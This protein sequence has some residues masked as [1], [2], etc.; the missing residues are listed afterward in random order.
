MQ[1]DYPVF[2][3]TYSDEELAEHFLLT[4]AEGALVETCRGDVNRHGIA[5]LLKTVQYLGYF[6]DTL[7]RVPEVV[8]TFIAHQLHLL[9]DHTPAY[10]RHPST[11][12]VHV[13]VIRQHLGCRFPTGEDK[14]ALELWLRTQGALDAPTEDAL[15]EC[16]YIRLRA[17]G[18]ELPAPQE[19][20][21]L[22]QAALRGFFQDVYDQV[23]ARLSMPVRT[24]L[25][26]LLVVPPEET[27]SLFD[28]LKADPAAPGVQALQQ[29]VAML[30]ALRA[31]ALPGDVLADVPLKV[32]QLLKRRAHNED[33]SRMRAHPAPIRYTLLASFIHVRM[34]EVTDDT[35]RMTLD[36]IRRIETQTEKHLEKALL[37]DIKRVTGKVQLLYRIAEAVVEAPDGTIRNVLFPCV[38]EATFHDLVAEAKA[39]HPHYRIWYQ[40]IMRQKFVRHYRR[41]LPLILDHLTFC[42]ENRFQPVIKALA[43]IKQS[44]GTEGPYLPA[45]VPVEGVVSPRWRETVIEE[46]EGTTRINRPYYELCVLQRLERALKCKEIWVEGAYAFRNPSQD[47][48]VNWHHEDQRKVYYGTLQHPLD[49]T[50]FLDPLRHRLTQALTQFNR[51]LP[52]NPYVHLSTPAANEDRRLFTV[53]PLVAQPEP[54]S[55]GHLKDLIGQRYG[56]LDLVDIVL[57]ADRLVDFTRFFT[58]SGTKEVRS[59]DTLRPLLL[60]DLFA[61]GT[62]TGIKRVAN[63]NQH[64][65]FHE[66]LYVRKHYFSVEALRLAN[67][68]VV[69]KILAVRNPQLWGD[70]HACASD[71]KRFESWRQNLMTEWRSRY[72]GYGIL[73]YWHVETNAVC[74]YSQLRNFSFS[75][76]A[77]MIEGLIRHDTEMRVE[78]NFVDSHG[79]S[80][81]AFAFCHLLGGVRLMPRLKR[82]KYERLYV[83]DKGM[84]GTFPN[85][86]G[87]LSRPIRWDFIAQQYD[88][89]MKHAVA[90]KLGTATPEAILK[91]FNSYNVTH[92]TYKALAELGKVEKTIYLCEY[93]SSL[94]LRHEVEAGLNGVERWNEAND[95]IRYGRQGIFAT[96][97][98]E[99]Q[100]IAALCLQLIQNCL[101]LINAILVE[102]TVAQHQ[103][104]EHFS[105]ED[106]RA[107]TPLFY[108]HVNPYGLVAL[109]VTRPSFL[110][111]A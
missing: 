9:W 71:G 82:I 23:A 41:M 91:R 79:Q 60:L 97:S 49:V 80:E 4:P 34:M 98:R 78:K 33:A 2:K 54:Q 56:M 92:P 108:E 74:I 25:D 28:R 29:E 43:A 36:V 64:Y 105:A 3:V 70:G 10:P 42:S 81:V 100:E 58:H 104:L 109:D 35:V 68:A 102:Q 72:K 8:R 18:I 87:V 101:V 57:E 20:Q 96:N 53:T 12:D 107:L 93:L 106:R 65:G 19:V 94:E 90:F 44:L 38:K 6:P 31:V 40:A 63:A 111:A 99:Q 51:D 24:A 83:P 95:F 48:P 26:A 86:A 61:E 73:V 13:A 32:V 27:H 88:E 45:D 76:V 85:L 17:L 89:M 14:Q 15:C 103:L 66:L 50:T 11:W 46:H 77:A 30:Q 69:N 67:A 5:V 75:E 55:L 21:R 1:G 39:S 22:V 52:R 37:Q 16:A 7:A 110:E 47:L 59:R 62:N 84:A